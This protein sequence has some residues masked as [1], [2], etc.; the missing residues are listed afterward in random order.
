MNNR[1]ELLLVVIGAGLLG[2][3]ALGVFDEMLAFGF[4]PVG[5]GA[6]GFLELAAAFGAP[7]ALVVGWAI[8]PLL[9]R[10]EGD[11]PSTAPEAR[12]KVPRPVRR[13]DA[14]FGAKE[15]HRSAPAGPDGALPI[16]AAFD[17]APAAIMITDARG[18][19][20]YVNDAFLRHCGYRREEVLGRRP[21]MLASG[22]TDKSVYR[23]LWQTILG[24]QTWKGELLNRR[25]GGGE[26]WERLMISPLR[27]AA[28]RLSHFVAVRE[29][30]TERKYKEAR[31]QRLACVDELSGVSNRR[32]LMERAEAERVQAERLDTP[33]TMLM[34]DVDHFKS[35]NDR[36]GHSAGD[37]AIRAV[38]R[39]C[40]DGLRAGDLAGR[41]GGEEFVVL[42]PETALTAAAA[43]AERLR[44]RIAGIEIEGREGV[45]FALTVSIGLTEFR[46]GQRLEDFIAAAD[47]ALYRAK[48][49]GRN[50]V[51]ATSGAGEALPVA[52]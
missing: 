7:L 37:R 35:I 5:A 36:H 26:R 25:K 1:A 31:L 24:G 18:R 40:R 50:R 43:L 11:S 3:A 9:R 28:G 27:D 49:L 20:E 19:I 22:R 10:P 29:D 17:H 45:P 46:R 38:G 52:Y 23:D 39:A 34:L 32:H 15:C 47:G 14:E 2:S 4:E 48:M 42:L 33:L 21:G 13:P 8:W 6:P 30:V 16:R 41:Y 12:L 44:E 51:E